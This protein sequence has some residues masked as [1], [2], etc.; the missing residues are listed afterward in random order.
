MKSNASY[1]DGHAWVV[2]GYKTTTIKKY[3]YVVDSDKNITSTKYL[4]TSY[5]NSFLSINWG[6]GILSDEYYAAG[7]F[8]PVNQ[9][10]NYQ[11]KQEIF[12]AGR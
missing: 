1:S 8:A 7:C 6:W 2:D 3:S 10:E 12:I 11:Y 5:S 9:D 4:S